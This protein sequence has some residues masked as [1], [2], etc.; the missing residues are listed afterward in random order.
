MK[1]DVDAVTKARGRDRKHGGL[2]EVKANV[3]VSS[4]GTPC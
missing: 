3:Y 4:K 1:V 2:L